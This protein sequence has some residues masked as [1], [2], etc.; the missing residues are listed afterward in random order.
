MR[1]LDKDP[2]K[3]FATAAEFAEALTKAPSPIAAAPPAANAEKPKPAASAGGRS[4]HSDTLVVTGP[5][6]QATG[7][8]ES[9]WDNAPEPASRRKLILIVVGLVVAA[10]VAWVSLR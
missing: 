4:S 6:P 8:S 7:P 9:P 5:M 1:A 3:R 2:N 10:V